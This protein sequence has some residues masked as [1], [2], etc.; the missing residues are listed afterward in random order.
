MFKNITLAVVQPDTNDQRLDSIL[1]I[2]PNLND[3]VKK[4][5]FAPTNEKLKL[6]TVME[7]FSLLVE[8]KN[9]LLT[10]SSWG[11]ENLWPLG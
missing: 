1:E 3:S 9:L 5:Q 10:I 8:F 2:F 4:A 11:Q 6:F 7:M